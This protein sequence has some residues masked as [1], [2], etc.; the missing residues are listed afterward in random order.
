MC[1][2]CTASLGVCSLEDLFIYLFVEMDWE[3]RFSKIAFQFVNYTIF[4]YDGL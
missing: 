2:A 4:S 3:H 1:L